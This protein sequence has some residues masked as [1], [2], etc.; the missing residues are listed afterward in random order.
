MLAAQL[1]HL[2]NLEVMT[3]TPIPLRYTLSR[4]QRLVPQLRI[5]GT[6]T[7]LLIAVVILFFP[8]LLFASLL[9]LQWVG[10]AVF[11]ALA[12]WPFLADAGLP[13]G[14][15]VPIRDMGVILEEDAAGILISGK[16]W[17]LFLDGIRELKQYREDTWTIQHANGWILHIA[18]SVLQEDHLAH[19]RAALERGRT[20][21]GIQAVIERGRRIEAIEDGLRCR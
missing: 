11:C 20:P 1:P 14:L 10:I 9:A 8:T 15:L 13:G 5:W 6:A 12:F 21:K 17:Y 16:R 7:A 3:Q 2:S 4:M 18:A 19:L